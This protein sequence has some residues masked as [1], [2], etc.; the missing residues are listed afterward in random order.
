FAAL[1]PLSATLTVGTDVIQSFSPKIQP[2]FPLVII[3]PIF[4]FLVASIRHAATGSELP[5]SNEDSYELTTR[6][7]IC[8]IISITFFTPIEDNIPG[9]QTV[10]FWLLA[11]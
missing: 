10:I 11:D 3:T 5:D 8:P 4:L 9:S 7:P 6:K 2:F 1:K